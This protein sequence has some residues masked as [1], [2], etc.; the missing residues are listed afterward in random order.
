MIRQTPRVRRVLMTRLGGAT[1]ESDRGNVAG[2]FSGLFVLAVRVR[3]IAAATLPMCVRRLAAATLSMCVRRLAAATL[4]MCVRRLAA[5]TLS[6]FARE[7]VRALGGV[8]RRICRLCP[9]WTGAAV[10]CRN[11]LANELLDIAQQRCLFGV[12]QRNRYSIGS[13]PRR[14][15][16]A[17][18]VSLGDVRQIEINDMADAVHID[19]ASG[20]I[21]GDQSSDRSLAES[22]EHPLA[23]AL[24]LVAVDRFGGDAGLDQPARDLVGAALGPGKD[25]SAVDC[26]AFQD[27]D[28]DGGFRGAVDTDDALLDAPDRRGTRRYRNI[29][30]IAQH[31]RGEFGDGARHRRRKQQRLSLRRKLGDD[32]ADV[33]NEAHVEHSVGFVEDKAFDTAQAKR[34]LLDKIEQP[35]WRGDKNIDAS[36]QR[37]HL[38]PHRDP[39][40]HQRARDAKM[41]AVGAEAVENLPRQFAC[42][43]EHQDAAAFALQGSWISGKSM[44]DRQREGCRFPGSG[45]GNSDHVAL[46][47]DDRY[48]LFLDRSC[49]GV[50]LFRDCTRNCFVKAEAVKRGQ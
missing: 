50:F 11:G 45:L 42:R 1:Q 21:G 24:R 6:L 35:P 3:R 32:F 8:A 27:I 2:G 5:A 48:R 47:Q 14:A 19:T 28:E 49:G 41:A 38:R 22:R 37:A 13:R 15:A 34:I 16:D 17:V 33:V 12:A 26:L 30:R 46:R 7:T 39:A 18:H 43:A 25:E 40:N 31:L 4:P 36:E 20:D 44:Q 10:S 29:D 23:L 9:A